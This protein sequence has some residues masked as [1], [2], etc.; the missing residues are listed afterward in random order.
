MGVIALGV[1]FG[2]RL[3][4]AGA[5]FHV[6]NHAAAKGLA[7]FGSGSLL[8]RYDTKEIDGI[9]G[10]AT[11]AAVQ[12]ADVPRRGARPLRPARLRRLPQRGADR[13]RRVRAGRRT[14]GSRCCSCSSTSPSSASSGTPAGWCSRPP[15][16]APSAGETSWWMVGAM[17]ACLVV[18]VGLGLHLP[19]PLASLLGH[20][21][22]AA[23]SSAD[24]LETRCA[25]VEDPR[26]RAASRRL[27]R[28]RR[29]GSAGESGA[30][31]VP[32]SQLADRAPRRCSS[33]AAASSR[34]LPRRAARSRRCVAAV[35]FQGELRRPAGAARGRRAS[36]P[37][38]SRVSPAAL[39][40]ERELHDVHG[41]VPLGQ[42]R[43]ASRSCRPTR[44]ASSAGSST[45]R[46]F[47]IP[48]GPIRSGRLR[49]GPVRDRDRR[50]GRAR[51]RTFGRSSS[52]GGSS[53]ASPGWGSSTPSSSPSGSP[54]SPPSR[55]RPPSARRSS[56][57]S[58]S[59]RPG[60]RSA[61][62][63]STPSSS[64][65]PTISTSRR[66]SPRMRP[67][68]S[69]SPAS[70]S[71]RSRSSGCA[72][73]S[74]G[75]ASAA[76]SSSRAAS[77]RRRCSS[78]RAVLRE[79][80]RFERDLRRDRRLLLAHDLVHR[81][82]DRQRLPRPGHDRG[83]TPASG[84]SPGPAARPW[85]RA[86]S[87]RTAPTSGSAGGSRPRDDG[88]AMARL[89]RTLRRDR[90][91]PPRDQAGVRAARQV[92]AR[93]CAAELPRRA[94]APR[95]AGRRR[96]WASSSTGSRSPEGASQTARIS[97]PSL[98]NWPLFAESFR[99]DVL[100]DFS[101]IEHSFGLTPAGADR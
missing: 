13:K 76:A 80:E 50:R 2:V 20:A 95:S 96:R 84:R 68:P 44:T 52:T 89:E 28:A 21:A 94:R 70:G 87:D 97:S 74:A 86:S 24:E 14:S 72:R 38:L 1:G 64:A 27:A 7:F 48:Y 45:R 67:S 35:S 101:F 47:V 98:R 60:G 6:L 11:C 55:T 56:A 81:P 4:V 59:S 40:P 69:P 5:L 85:T 33:G 99:G 61:G 93:S 18:V 8:R 53:N 25:P 90:R 15:R 91:E 41:L 88:D 43:P 66:S 51:A 49:V 19:A 32:L 26:E 30:S 46:P 77:A 23:G 29:A 100:T 31:G 37:S 62:A 16:R 71:S 79:L 54:E 42:V 39:L 83:A 82:A 92:R 65:S 22:D 57:R 78:R 75:A 73:V 9:R 58:G 10:A 3:A 36:I 63:S 17:A 34:C 12:R